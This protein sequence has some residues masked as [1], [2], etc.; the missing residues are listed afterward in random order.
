MIHNA[1]VST[2][3]LTYRLC[4]CDDTILL[5]ICMSINLSAVIITYNVIKAIVNSRKFKV[6]NNR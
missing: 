5:Y 2:T 3:L 6:I 4:D 1:V